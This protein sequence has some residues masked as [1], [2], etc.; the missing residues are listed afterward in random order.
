MNKK[1]QEDNDGCAYLLTV[2]A[3]FLIGI[4]LLGVIF[5]F[6]KWEIEYFIFIF[7]GLFL[8]LLE[9]WISKSKKK[10]P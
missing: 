6:G 10:N 7:V 1:K 5:S 9:G 4:G 8:R 2:I 3:I